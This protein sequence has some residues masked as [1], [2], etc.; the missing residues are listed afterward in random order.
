MEILVLLVIIT[1]S[2]IAALDHVSKIF[3]YIKN[4]REENH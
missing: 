4:N 1:F 3:N 2:V